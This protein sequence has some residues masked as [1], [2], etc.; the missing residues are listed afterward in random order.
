MGLYFKNATVSPVWVVY[1]REAPG[2][3]GGVDWAKAGWYEI[4]PAATVKVRSGWV[5]GDCW[6]YY[7]EDESDTSGRARTTPLFRGMPSI[8]AGTRRPLQERR[9]G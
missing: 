9:S 3:E 5:G 2:C 7:A 1:G 4:A 8:G 6:M